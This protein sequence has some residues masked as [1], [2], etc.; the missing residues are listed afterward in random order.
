MIMKIF[1]TERVVCAAC[2]CAASLDHAC[3]RLLSTMPVRGFARIAFIKA[4]FCV[5]FL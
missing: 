5:L 4:V 2:L 3:A 1:Y